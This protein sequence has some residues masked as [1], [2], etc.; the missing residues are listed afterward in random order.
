MQIG[1]GELWES[2]LDR[3]ITAPPIMDM[4]ITHT[5]AVTIEHIPTM[6]TTEDGHTTGITGIEF[7]TTTIIIIIIATIK[8]R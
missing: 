1:H 7:T 3:A 6:G 5:A 4:D 2:G 8:L